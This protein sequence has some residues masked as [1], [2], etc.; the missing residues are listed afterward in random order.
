MI[1][2]STLV[3]TLRNLALVAFTVEV[4]RLSWRLLARADQ[5]VS[6]SPRG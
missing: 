4:C 2:I 5:R 3:T 6:S 1:T